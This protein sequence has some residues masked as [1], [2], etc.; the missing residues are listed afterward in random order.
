MREFIYDRN[1]GL[2][3]NDRL[4]V[5]LFKR[6]AAVLGATQGHSFEIAYERF[7]IG[8][9]VRLDETDYDVDSLSLQQVGLF[10]HLI[11]LADTRSSAQVYTQPRAASLLLFGE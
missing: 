10:Q 4:H 8:A 2:A 6:H 5:H 1:S 3:S 11:S 7:S 9:T